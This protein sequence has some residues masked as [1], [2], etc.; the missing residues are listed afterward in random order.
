MSIFDAQKSLI[1]MKRIALIITSV[2]LLGLSSYAQYSDK[3][4]CNNEILIPFGLGLDQ[5]AGDFSS[6]FG[7]FK[8]A[9]VGFMYKNRKQLVYGIQY[10]YHFGARLKDDSMFDPV[11]DSNGDFIAATGVPTI[12]NFNGV[13]HHGKAVFGKIFTLW[14]NNPNNGLL[15]MGGLGFFQH[16]IRVDIADDDIP[17]LNYTYRKGYDRLS[18][19]VSFNQFVG[20]IHLAESKHGGRQMFVPTYYFGFDIN[21]AWV[22]NRRD[23]NYDLFMKDDNLY[24]DHLLTFRVGWLIHLNLVRKNDFHYF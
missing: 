3:D 13:A 20:Y 6:R 23:W 7:L 12:V 5:T 15:L 18:N 24:M 10:S 8:S 14:D 1:R 2:F 21:T 22:K 19:G 9:H 4:T 16:K 17:Q 11:R